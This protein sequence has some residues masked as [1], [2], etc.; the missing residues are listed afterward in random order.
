MNYELR[1]VLVTT[2]NESIDNALP[3]VEGIPIAMSKSV[4]QDY[5]TGGKAWPAAHHSRQQRKGAPT[6]RE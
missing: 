6:R 1:I 3:F 4:A 5:K 2:Q